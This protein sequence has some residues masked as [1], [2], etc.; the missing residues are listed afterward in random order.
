M[1]ISCADLTVVNK[2]LEGGSANTRVDEIAADHDTC[3]TFSGFAMNSDNIIGVLSEE[4]G[5]VFAEVM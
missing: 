1:L 5:H 2:G 4:L 3:T